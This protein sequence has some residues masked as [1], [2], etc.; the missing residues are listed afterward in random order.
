MADQP[1]TS[2]SSTQREPPQRS[3]AQDI[4][5]RLRRLELK[6][7]VLEKSLRDV[8]K[9]VEQICDTT[10]P[11]ESTRPTIQPGCQK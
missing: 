7:E 5:H 10:M 8:E 1:K 4:E 3:Q 11:P 2:Q 9:L 6:I